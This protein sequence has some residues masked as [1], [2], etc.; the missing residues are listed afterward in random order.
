MQVRYPDAGHEF[1]PAIRNEAYQFI[2]QILEHTPANNLEAEL[3]RIPPHEPADALA[4]F[5]VHEGFHLEQAAAEPL[6]ASPV[7]IDFDADGR[8]YIAEMRD[9]SE[10]D[11]ERLGRVRVLEDTDRDGRF[12]KA[13]ILAERLSWPTAIVCYDGGAFVGAAPDIVYLKDTDGDGRADVERVVF[14]GFERSNVQGLLNSFHWGPDNRIHGATST[15]GGHVRRADMPGAK[16]ISLNGRDF[17]F[18]ARTLELRPESGGAQHGMCF[19]DWGR[20]FVCSNSDHIQMVMF[21]DRYVARNPSVSAPS[22]RMSIA[23]DGP[24]AEVFR[25]S[26]VEPWRIVRTRLR[27]AGA[28]EGPIEGGG[29]AG[30][31][32][33][34]ATGTTIFRGDAWPAEYVGQAFVGDVGSNNRPP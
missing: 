12:D 14:T 1:P 33:T 15:S 20:K 32:F 30:G 18:D 10:Q 22:S 24:Q 17:S 16:P 3:P 4:T 11:K 19:D 23:A 21:E 7:A 29:R 28:A 25:A 13:T 6:V 9:Y 27:V 5:K 2:D 34:G 31:Y 8:L 26:A